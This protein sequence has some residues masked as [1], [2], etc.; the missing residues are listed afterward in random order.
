V[1]RLVGYK[2]F[3]LLVDVLVRLRERVPDLAA[4]IAGEGSEQA[5]LQ[6]RIDRYGASSW[7]Q[8]AAGFLTGR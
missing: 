3:D 5:A 6:A 7:L 2:R 1:G 8:L 4:V